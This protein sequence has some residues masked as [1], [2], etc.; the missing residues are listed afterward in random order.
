MKS[1]LNSTSISFGTRVCFPKLHSHTNKFYQA[2]E[3]YCSLGR[4]KARILQAEKGKHSFSVKFE[5][6]SLSKKKLFKAVVIRIALGAT[7]ILPMV[8]L[9][10]KIHF[11]YKNSFEVLSRENSIS[12]TENKQ[13]SLEETQKDEKNSQEAGLDKEIISNFEMDYEGNLMV[14]SAADLQSLPKKVQ[15]SLV[16]KSIE[17][18]FVALNDSRVVKLEAKSLVL[19]DLNLMKKLALILKENKTLRSLDLS[20]NFINSEGA[21]ELAAA[22]KVNQTLTSLDFYWNE[23]GLEGVKEF[24]SMLKTNRTL[25]SLDLSWSRIG[26]EEVKELREALKVNQALISL[27]LSDNQINSEGVKELA[28]A[29]KENQSLKSLNLRR[30]HFGRATES[31]VKEILQSNKVLQITW[32]EYE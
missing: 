16:A 20:F 26:Q 6:T 22:L 8:A 32:N 10:G 31:E 28:E 1:Q 27:N 15:I 2:C 23:M 3:W 13:K 12:K 29:L 4:R 9:L 19:Q 5:N 17:E 14:S 7:G 25:T 30:N 18:M 11:R 24:A 21:K